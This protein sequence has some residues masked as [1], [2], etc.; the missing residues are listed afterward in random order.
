MMDGH[1]EGWDPDDITVTMSGLA[2]DFSMYDVYLYIG[3]DAGGRTGSFSINGGAPVTFTSELFNGTFT[4]VTSPGQTG[5]YIRFA[6]ITG[7]SFSI[8]GGGDNVPNRTGVRGIEVVQ[9][10]AVPEPT[11]TALLALGLLGAGVYRRRRIQ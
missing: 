6:G 9:A 10:M 8:V 7:D 5:S 3:D 11:T 2:D 1:F 4:E